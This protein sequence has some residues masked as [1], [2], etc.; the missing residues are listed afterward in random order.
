MGKLDVFGGDET[1]RACRLSSSRRLTG[2]TDGLC[3]RVSEPELEGDS[4]V[5]KKLTKE[6]RAGAT[7]TTTR[8]KPPRI[9]PEQE[10]IFRAATLYLIQNH[11]MFLVAT[12]V[13]EARVRGCPVWI[14]TVTLRFTTGHEGYIGDLLY[15]GEEFTFL[16]EKSVMDERANQ[17]ANDPERQRKWNEYRASTLSAAER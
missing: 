5:V 15:D 4:P 2:G 11:G 17:I 14:I 13:R 10:R 9:V 7:R 16:T 8:R 12:G 6:V 3:S 1:R